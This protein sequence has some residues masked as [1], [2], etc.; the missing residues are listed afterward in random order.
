MKEFDEIVRE[1]GGYDAAARELYRLNQVGDDI[2]T[3]LTQRLECRVE[4]VRSKII[5]IDS[6]EKTSAR[7]VDEKEVL[8]EEYEV[9]TDELQQIID[10]NE[11]KLR[12]VW[13]KGREWLD[14]AEVNA[15]CLADMAQIR[16]AHQSKTQQTEA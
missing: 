2:I 13:Y 3:N 8:K 15:L 11:Y 4:E 14:L 7:L 5:M 10:S 6:L 16:A 1:L 12:T 9:H